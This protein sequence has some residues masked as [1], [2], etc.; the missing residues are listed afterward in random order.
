[1]GLRPETFVAVGATS[2]GGEKVPARLYDGVAVREGRTSGA[3]PTRQ[4]ARSGAM[5]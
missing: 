2:C 4:T 1:M 5:A 3:I